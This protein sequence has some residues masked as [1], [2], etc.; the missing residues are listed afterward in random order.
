MTTANHFG[1]ISRL[2]FGPLIL[3]AGLL[4]AGGCMRSAP[5]ASSAIVQALGDWG[6]LVGETI[7][8]AGRAENRKIGPYLKMA[9]GGVWVEGTWRGRAW[10]ASVHG[11]RV[12]VTG[13]VA[14]RHD[15]PVYVQR[16]GELSLAGIPVPE[17]TDLHEASRRY[18]LVN[19]RYEVADT[20]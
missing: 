10:P 15:L 20:D 12:V 11:R 19:A 13:T 5:P 7:R 14:V 17:G 1:A 4:V 2:P 6:Q 18:V 3:A 16:P 9:D 8:V